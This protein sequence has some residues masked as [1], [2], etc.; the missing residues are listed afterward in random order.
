LRVAIHEAR[1]SEWPAYGRLLDFQGPRLAAGGTYRCGIGLALDAIVP[2]RLSWLL[3]AESKPNLRRRLEAGLRGMGLAATLLGGE[4]LPDAGQSP[5]AIARAGAAVETGDRLFAL[6]DP[7]TI[8]SCPWEPVLE[9]LAMA[10]RP[11][12]H[13]IAVAF[14][15]GNPLHAWPTD[16]SPAW[17]LRQISRIREGPYQLA[18]YATEAV[19]D[20]AARVLHG[21]G[22][23]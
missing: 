1:R 4:V 3:A 9:G 18:A 5:V 7:F 23:S 21:F 16:L 14:T 15:Y 2:N 17:Q 22:W 12:A 19:A 10:L 13:A 20:D 6:I 11:G 8:P